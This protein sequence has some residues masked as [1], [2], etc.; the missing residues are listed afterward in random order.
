MLALNKRDSRL[1]IRTREFWSFSCEFLTWIFSTVEKNLFDSRFWGRLFKTIRNFKVLLTW[2]ISVKPRYHRGVSHY[3]HCSRLLKLYLVHLV[4]LSHRQIPKW[5]NEAWQWKVCSVKKEKK[6]KRNQV[7]LSRVYRWGD[8]RDGVR[9]I[10]G[11]E[12]RTKS[13]QCHY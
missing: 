4:N 11:D 12:V 9:C 7:C 6:K 3:P 1:D 5:K 10:D 2:G 8:E 13:H